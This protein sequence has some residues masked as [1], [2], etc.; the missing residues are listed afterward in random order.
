MKTGFYIRFLERDSLHANMGKFR[1]T[2]TQVSCKRIGEKENKERKQR[3]K[4]K[5]RREERLFFPSY[6]KGL[7]CEQLPLSLSRKERHTGNENNNKKKLRLLF[8]FPKCIPYGQDSLLNY[9]NMNM[10][11]L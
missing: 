1:I 8:P 7:G 4:R 10:G 2:I 11:Y 9:W 3:K 6:L 5:K